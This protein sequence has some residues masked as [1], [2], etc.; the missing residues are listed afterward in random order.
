M[1]NTPCSYDEIVR[2]TVHAGRDVCA[3][4]RYTPDGS[5]QTLALGLLCVIFG[6]GE[7]GPAWQECTRALVGSAG[8]SIYGPV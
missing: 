5:R 3:N 2:F 6:D 4:V 7:S 1:P 8:P